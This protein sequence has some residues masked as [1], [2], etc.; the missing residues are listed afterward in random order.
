M[1]EGCEDGSSGSFLV[2]VRAQVMTRDDSTGGWVPMGGGGL[3]NVSVRKRSITPE[4]TNHEYLI[5]GKRIS[6]QSV[7]LSCLI[8]KD[9]EY[10]KVM[11]TFHHWK[12]GEKKFGL[13][14]Q[15]AAD[16]RAFDKGVRTAIEELLQVHHTG[17]GPIL[18][19]KSDSQLPLP[20]PPSVQACPLSGIESTHHHA[21]YNED[22]GDDDV[23]MTL[24]LPVE[25]GDSQ[26]SSESS[27]AKY[28]ST[29][30]CDLTISG[31]PRINYLSHHSIDSPGKGS[32]PECP[33]RVKEPPPGG[34]GTVGGSADNYSY[35]QLTAVHEYIYPSIE[36]RRDSLKKSSLE[37]PLTSTSSVQP[38]L[39]SKKKDKRKNCRHC[40]EHFSEDGNPRGSCEYAPDCVRSAVDYVTCISCAQCMLYHC[41]ADEEGEF[42]QQ[43][44]DCNPVEENWLAR[45]R[46]WIGLAL[47]SIIVPCLCCYPPLRACHWCCVRCGVCGGRHE[48][49]S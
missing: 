1:T 5:F 40:Q 11:P 30:P 24:N 16:A 20:L 12:T 27:G 22:P 33:P 2:R 46:R 28:S 19:G 18:D 48:A 7:V 42:V 47:L 10:H 36:D 35:V 25:R 39:P 13:T 34:G 44:C 9:F 14:F 21:N 3:S 38:A 23:F 32:G 17:N 29:Q 37:T 31:H 45:R 8:K 43:P 6:D 49:N 15:T 4:E 41:M 26:S